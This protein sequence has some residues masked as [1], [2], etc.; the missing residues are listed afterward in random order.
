MKI[1][2]NIIFIIILGVFFFL[3]GAFIESTFDI[4]VWDKTLKG[5]LASF[6]WLFWALFLL[7][8]NTNIS[9]NK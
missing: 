9:E 6:L 1:L 5:I 8:A 3:T 2:M 4:S 7:V